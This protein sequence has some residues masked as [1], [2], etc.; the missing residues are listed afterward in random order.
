MA[1]IMSNMA[2]ASGQSNPYSIR[3]ARL[4]SMLF[5]SGGLEFLH[6]ILGCSDSYLDYEHHSLVLLRKN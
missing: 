2:N 3:V 1:Y 5:A 6:D 4:Y